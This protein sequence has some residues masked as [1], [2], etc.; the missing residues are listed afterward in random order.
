MSRGSPAFTDSSR[1]I[2]AVATGPRLVD[3]EVAIRAVR[4]HRLTGLA[5]EAIRARGTGRLLP[6]K[7]DLVARTVPLLSLH[8]TRVSSLDDLALVV[9]QPIASTDLARKVRSQTRS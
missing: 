6:V 2:M 1:A 8:T 3:G 7:A 5:W 9:D 4:N